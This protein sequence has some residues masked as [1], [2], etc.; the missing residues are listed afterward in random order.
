MLNSVPFYFSVECDSTESDV[1]SDQNPPPS[2]FID[3]HDS[4]PNSAQAVE[5]GT[6]LKMCSV[7]YLI[8][9]YIVR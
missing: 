7:I 2:D 8:V 3:A 6:H 9:T 1:Q 5:A 4:K